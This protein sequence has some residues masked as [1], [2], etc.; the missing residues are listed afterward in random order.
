[1]LW[2]STIQRA[3]LLAAVLVP[4]VA[5]ENIDP[6]N[7][8]SQYAWGENIGWVNFEPSQGPGVSVSE[9]RLT[10]FAWAENI[11][12]VNLS[13]RTNDTCGTVEFG[14]ANDGTG[15]LSGFA[16]GEN[17]GWINFN[18]VVPGDS[19]R[20]GVTIDANGSFSGWAWGENIGWIHFQSASPVA[21]KVQ[22]CK[23]S[24]DDLAHFAQAWL[25]TGIAAADLDGS[26]KT[27]V[28]DFAIFAN[29]WQRFCPSGWMLK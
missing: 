13:C 25:Q 24:L 9:A 1:M 15:N 8:N 19:T 21:F 18:P 17:V 12:W 20:Y 14:V 10:G 7:D 28:A 27:D 11:G 2:Q 26:G 4:W 23:V 29:Y 6:Y 3:V 16:W 5:A 22:A